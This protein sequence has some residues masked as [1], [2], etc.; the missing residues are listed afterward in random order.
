MRSDTTT[1]CGGDVSDAQHTA[2]RRCFCRSRQ[3]VF[4]EGLPILGTTA[5]VKAAAV[6]LHTCGGQNVHV[7]KVAPVRHVAQV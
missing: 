5:P 7:G 2:D 3:V 6:A 4:D 1:I